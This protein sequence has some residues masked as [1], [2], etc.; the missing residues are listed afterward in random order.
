[1]KSIVI[2]INH[3]QP[4]IGYQE[5]FLAKEWKK[6]DHKVT[7]VTSN[8]FFPFPNYENT[9]QSI[10]GERKREIGRKK[11]RGID[12]IR[13]KSSF[14]LPGGFVAWLDNLEETLAKL[15]PDLV[16]ADGVFQPLA[17]QISLI[18]NKQ[19]FLLAFDSHASSFNT[20]LHSSFLKKSYMFLF[21]K[22]LIPKIKSAANVFTAVGES[23]RKTLIKEYGLKARQV[24]LIHLGADTSIFY[25]DLKSRSIIRKKLKV[26][27]KEILFVYAGKITKN[28]DV[29]VLIPAFA[30][31]LE[32]QS[33][34]KLLIIGTGADK[35]MKKLVNLAKESNCYENI[36]WL[37]QQKHKKLAQY[38]NAADI[39]VW[40]GD[41]SNTIQECMACGKVVILAN[42]I[43]KQQS[44]KHLTKSMGVFAFKRGSIRSLSRVMINLCSSKTKLTQLGKESQKTIVTEFSWKQ[45]AKKHLEVLTHD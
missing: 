19:K 29:H 4:K 26:S 11:E 42:K 40:P 31:L 8:Y 21:Q 25:P 18:K 3:F 14:Q 1:M 35:Y 30:K 38:Y 22:L 39:G 15:K 16:F 5:F 45:I 32:K 17:L 28:K 33:K 2:L 20:D 12:S 44:S 34:S 9:V 27:D 36:I 7:V 24:R 10:L 13:L 41:L 43:S 6:L 23:E 37:P